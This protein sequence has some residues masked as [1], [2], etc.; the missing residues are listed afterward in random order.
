MD[1]KELDVCSLEGRKETVSS[2]DGDLKVIKRDMRLIG[3]YKSLAEGVAGLEEAS[4]EIQVAI[5]CRLKNINAD[6][7]VSKDCIERSEAAQ[8]QY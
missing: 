1:N 2:I 7:K 4:F 8:S 6:S 5:K 3:D